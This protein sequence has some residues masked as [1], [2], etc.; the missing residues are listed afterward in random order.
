MTLEVILIITVLILITV[1]FLLLSKKNVKTDTSSLQLLQ[2]QIMS[3]NKTIDY[4]LG[5][6]NRNLSKNFEINSKINIDATR[7]IEEI[8]KKLTSLEETNKQIKDIG[9]QL[10]WLESILKNPKQRGNLWEYFLKELL[11]NVFWD[12]QYKM[13]YKIGNVWFVDAALFIWWKTIPIDSKFP[14]DNYDKLIKANDTVSIK[15]FSQ[16]LTRDIKTK[17]DQTSKYI[18]TSL[19]TT[20]FAFMLIPAEWLY[21]DIFISKIG[22]MNPKQIIEYAF[23]KKVIIC[24]PSWFYAYLQT[25]IQWLKSLE[26]E[27]KTK[28]IQKQVEKLAKHLSAY[29]EY[30]KKLWWSLGTTVNHYNNANKEFWKIDKD[31]VKITGEKQ[32]NGIEILQLDKPTE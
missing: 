3:L 29:E 4:K 27:K 20:N 28:E 1:I 2:E 9:W 15:T 6:S 18:D 30:I 19:E 23:S 32:W 12:Y 10:E 16:K 25:V 8:T 5:E 22:D 14:Q 13:E 26:I 21:Y 7:K 31:V 24:S 11:D 17:I